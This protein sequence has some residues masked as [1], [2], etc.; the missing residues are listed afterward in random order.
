MEYEWVAN[1]VANLQ[2]KILATELHA[3]ACY[4]HAKCLDSI[5]CCSYYDQPHYLDISLEH[6]YL[7]NSLY[8]QSFYL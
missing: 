4:F 8:L 5:V 2:K 6:P 3:Q 7:H 1:L